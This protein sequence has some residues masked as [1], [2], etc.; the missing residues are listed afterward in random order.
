[1]S[2]TAYL[3]INDLFTLRLSYPARA[4]TPAEIR[5]IGVLNAGIASR[6]GNALYCWPPG[7]Q[8]SEIRAPVF[9]PPSGDKNPNMP[10]VGLLLHP[11]AYIPKLEGARCVAER[12]TLA[13]V[14]KT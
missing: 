12:S 10:S 1:M 3:D 8:V 11:L 7:G 9:R 4:D 13:N 2:M 5:I 6:R 14:R